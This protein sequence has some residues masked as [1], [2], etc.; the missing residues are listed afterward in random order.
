M[1]T[2]T[3]EIP[4]ASIVTLRLLLRENGETIDAWVCNS[5]VGC[6]GDALVVRAEPPFPMRVEK[7]ADGH[8]LHIIPEGFLQ[9]GTDYTLTVE[10]NVYTG[11]LPVG[12]LTLGGKKRA[13]I[14]DTI[15]LRTRATGGE[16]LPM[17]VGDDEVTALEWTRLAVPIPPMMPSLNQ[18]GFDYLDWIIGAV[19]ITDPDAQGG[20]KATLWAIG[21][22][23]DS[24]G[25]LVADP[26]SDFT[27]PLSGRYQD[28]AF[29]LTDQDFVMP[30]TGIPIPFNLFELRGQLAGDL[31]VEPGATVYADTE[32]LSIPTFG[33]YLVIAGL[34]NNWFEKLLV[35]GTYL[36]RPYEDGSANRRPEGLTVTAL[37]YIPATE[38]QAGKVTA[39]FELAAGAS[40]R[41]DEHRPGILLMD[42]AQTQ[43]VYLDYHNNLSSTADA[44]G[45]VATV[46]LTI[47]AGTAV[48]E[49]MDAIVLADVFPLFRKSL[50]P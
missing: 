23:R 22:K 19:D 31:R 8:F 5:P 43:A 30:V 6:P 20:G 15:T 21:A 2:G 18:I 29:I 17:K 16:A 13:R 40:Y 50:A 26:E 28:N 48:P 47:P 12:N 11:G 42:T 27:L 36:T 14:E 44:S 46:T 35:A 33:P 41:L 45:N 32:A 38:K 34:A 1:L 25:R 24:E 49:Q 39:T 7:S 3:P 4:I 37:D 9:P 10:S